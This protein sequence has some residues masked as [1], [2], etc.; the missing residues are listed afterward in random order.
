MPKA[1][2]VSSGWTD[3][4]AFRVPP[5]A[6]GFIT[7][8]PKHPVSGFLLSALWALACSFLSCAL[9]TKMISDTSYLDIGYDRMVRYSFP[10][11]G[12]RRCPL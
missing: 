5:L 11:R 1:R 9:P 4:A 7:L 10:L 8:Q 2:P 3:E 12:D 6:V